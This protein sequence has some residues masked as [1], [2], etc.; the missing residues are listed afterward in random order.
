MDQLFRDGRG[1]VLLALLALAV[2]APAETG[3]GTS[4]RDALYRSALE[5]QAQAENNQ[6]V[7]EGI[8][9]FRQ[10]IAKCDAATKSQPDFYDAQALAAHCYNRLAQRQAAAPEHADLIKM[11]QE[12][13]ALAAVCSGARGALYRE[14]GLMLL[15]EA[16]PEKTQKERDSLL[17]E[18]RRVFETGLTLSGPTADRA[19]LESDLGHCLTLLAKNTDDLDDQHALCDE[20]LRRFNS[21]AKNEAVASQAELHAR[22]G[23]AL[24][25]SAKLTTSRTLF[26]QGVEQLEAALGKGSQ[27]VDAQY[28][29]SC[30]YAMLGQ[31][32]QALTHLRSCLNNKEGRRLYYQAA[33]HAPELRSLEALPAYNALFDDK[34]SGSS[35]NA[36]KPA[37]SDR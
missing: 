16:G 29:L 4:D 25:E 18:S 36:A 13:F 8:N 22:W 11:A 2:S 21:A 20:A 7:P 1:L 15:L 34:E 12:R 33:A 5:F 26:Q 23:A 32:D 27:S 10:A 17:R 24:V 14:W 3:A 9:N 35:S 28:N 30:A 37:L 6:L 31:S 19:N